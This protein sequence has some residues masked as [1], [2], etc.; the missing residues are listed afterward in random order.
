LKAVEVAA[1]YGALGDRGESEARNTALLRVLEHGLRASEAAALKVGTTATPYFTTSLF[2][3]PNEIHVI[4]V[5]SHGFHLERV[6]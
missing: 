5:I 2:I 1:L 4:N 3:V 6:L